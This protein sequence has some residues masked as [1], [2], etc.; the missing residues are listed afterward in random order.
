MELSLEGLKEYLSSLL[1][2]LLKALWYPIDAFFYN[3]WY[4]VVYFY[5]VLVA[6]LQAI[7]GL[8]AAI[9][10]YLYSSISFLPSP[11]V[12]LLL[13]AVSVVVLLRIYYF[14]KD[15]SIVGNKI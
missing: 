15:I 1:I 8:L 5:N 4:I 13:V 11:W 10:V 12:A 9:K 6:F 2:S 14:L 7:Y 3:L